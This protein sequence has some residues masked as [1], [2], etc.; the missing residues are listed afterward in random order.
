MYKYRSVCCGVCAW[1]KKEGWQR[2]G[3]KE[4]GFEAWHTA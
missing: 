4:S 1:E 3:T 2:G